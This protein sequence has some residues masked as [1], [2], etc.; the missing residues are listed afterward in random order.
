[1]SF[2]SRSLLTCSLMR[3]QATEFGVFLPS[4]FPIRLVPPTGATTK[5]CLNQRSL[6]SGVP[7]LVKIEWK[8]VHTGRVY[9]LGS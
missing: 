8:Q 7:V 5:T 6:T 3:G 9:H 2:T 1:M 4:T